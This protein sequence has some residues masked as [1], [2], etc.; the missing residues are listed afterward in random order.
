MTSICEPKKS[1]VSLQPE[2][3]LWNP[4]PKSDAVL[5]AHLGTTPVILE[6]WPKPDA[7]LLPEL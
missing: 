3:M 1:Y 4:Y 5:C 7:I 2:E 6:D